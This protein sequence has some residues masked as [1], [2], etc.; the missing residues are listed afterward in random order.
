MGLTIV[1]F[2]LSTG[3][4][5]MFVA[6]PVSNDIHGNIARYGLLFGAFLTLFVAFQALRSFHKIGNAIDRFEEFDAE[7]KQRWTNHL[8]LTPNAETQGGLV[9]SQ[10]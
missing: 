7:F 8:R 4:A 6:L 1:S 2:V 5:I 9:T 3:L 10:N